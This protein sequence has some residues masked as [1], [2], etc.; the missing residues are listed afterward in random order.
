MHVELHRP[1][2]ALRLVHRVA[3]AH[4]L[5]A[6]HHPRPV[7]LRVDVH[8]GGLDS[9]GGLVGGLEGRRVD[10]HRHVGDLVACDRGERVGAFAAAGLH[11]GIGTDDEPPTQL[12]RRRATRHRRGID[13]APL[14]VGLGRETPTSTAIREGRGGRGDR[15]RA[16][17]R[18]RMASP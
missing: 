3:Y 9:L 11:Q 8:E 15:G 18:S 5:G 4:A 7:H 1:A 17:A 13:P 6:D 16:S 10:D 14:S 2:V 12:Q